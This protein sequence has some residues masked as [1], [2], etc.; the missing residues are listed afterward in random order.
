MLKDLKEFALKGNV[1][2]MA[3]GI[4]IGAAF[5]T[6]VKTLVD[7]VVMPPLG[8]LTGRMDFSDKFLMLRAGTSSPPYR[9]LAEAKSAGAVLI[10]YGALV[11]AVLSFVIVALLLFFIVRWMNRLR[12]PDTPPPPSTKA[13][14]YC[15]STIDLTASRC[16]QCTSQLG[17][18]ATA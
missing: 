9:T 12:R 14:P 6:V 11:N 2:D 4:I 15:K 16:P 5:T 13:C 3:V 18:G 17:E 7:E 10:G 1:V 8:L